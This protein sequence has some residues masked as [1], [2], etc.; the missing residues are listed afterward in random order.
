MLK[1]IITGAILLGI[2]FPLIIIQS[3]FCEF[4]FLAVAIFLSV[5]GTYEYMNGAYKD[6]NCLKAYRYLI[7]I[8]SGF[9]TFLACNATYNASV[10]NNY[11]YHVYTLLF[12]IFGCIV[13][14]GSMIFVKNS[15]AIDIAHCLLAF[16]YGGLLFG[17]TLSL[18]YFVPQN[19]NNTFINLNGRQSFMFIYTIVLLTDTFAYLIGCKWGKHRLAP[20]ISPKKSIEGSIGGLVAGIV[21]GVSALFIYKIVPTTDHLALIIILGIILTALIS[22]SVQ[23]GDLIESKLKRTFEL[24]DFGKILPGHGG[25]L[26]RFD[27]LIYS[28]IVFYFFAMFIELI[29]LG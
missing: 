8:F 14:F 22:C 11:I 7:P 9:I 2:L 1:R 23:L 15:S 3:T 4:A 5:V 10:D 21:F 29:I 24:K 18:R 6:N 12:F 26:D 25:I 16:V 27:S 28:G 13:I 17:Y 20:S 19:I